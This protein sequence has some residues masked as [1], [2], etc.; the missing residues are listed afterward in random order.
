MAFGRDALRKEKE[1]MQR[2]TEP[3]G[4]P[5]FVWSESGETASGR[6]RHLK[7]NK[8]FRKFGMAFSIF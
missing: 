1:D 4:V 5:F 8:Q 2:Q 3:F 6:K 7:L